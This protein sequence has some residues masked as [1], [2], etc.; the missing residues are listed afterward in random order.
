MSES[1]LAALGP[2]VARP[3]TEEASL[4][5]L[6]Q[7]YAQRRVAVLLGALDNN[8]NDPNL[9][10]SCAAMMQG[11]QRLERGTWFQASL[12][13]VYGDEGLPPEH[14]FAVVPG[15][16][17][18]STGMIKS[19]AARDLFFG[20]GFACLRAG[21]GGTGD[22]GAGAAGGNAGSPAGGSVGNNSAAGTH[23]ALRS[24]ALRLLLAVAVVAVAVCASVIAG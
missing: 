3:P 11:S 5:A 9:A 20:C 4:A 22:A 8:E 18:S 7:R 19:E 24:V 17:H 23:V 1:A 21:G 10:S 15:V 16:G 6:R 2:E 12:S 14:T 13:V